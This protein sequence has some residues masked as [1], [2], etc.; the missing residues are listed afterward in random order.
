MYTC[1]PGNQ[2]CPVV[3]REINGT[4]EDLPTQACGTACYLEIEYPCING[5]LG[6]HKAMSG[7]YQIVS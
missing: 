3:K 2:L 7:D 1:W 5:T 4:V 6:P